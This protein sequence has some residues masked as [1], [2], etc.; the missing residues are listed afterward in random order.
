MTPME[1]LA[2]K[3]GVEACLKGKSLDDNSYESDDLAACWEDGYD[4]CLATGTMKKNLMSGLQIFVKH[5]T[6]IGCD[7]S[8]ETF[9]GM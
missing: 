7:P 3:D 9:W 2:Y 6:P 1:Q 8:S 5:G 4:D